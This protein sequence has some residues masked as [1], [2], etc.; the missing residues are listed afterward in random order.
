M[1]PST[2]LS[3]FWSSC[4]VWPSGARTHLDRGLMNVL[5]L[6]SAQIPLCGFQMMNSEHKFTIFMFCS[7]QARREQV[8]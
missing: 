7:G 3:L 8:F 1:L 5:L 2:V 4:E 6:T